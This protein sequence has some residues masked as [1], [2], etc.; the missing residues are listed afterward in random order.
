MNALVLPGEEAGPAKICYD[1][2]Q[3]I[4]MERK[5]HREG[6]VTSWKRKIVERGNEGLGKGCTSEKG[7]Q[8]W[9]SCTYL[10]MAGWRDVRR[11]DA[12]LRSPRKGFR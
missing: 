9:G 4:L 6:E 3:E 11:L 5:E 10:E 1:H 7:S 8:Y 12:N 2:S